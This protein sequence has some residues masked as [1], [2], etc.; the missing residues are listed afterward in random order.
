VDEQIIDKVS[1]RAA[2]RRL[3]V[4]ALGGLA[5]AAVTTIP[6][7]AKGGN[8]SKGGKRRKKRKT[9]SGDAAERLIQAKCASQGDQCRASLTEICRG[10]S[11]CLEG[12]ICCDFF[13]TCN[14]PAGLSCI[15]A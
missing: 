5:L 11:N 10:E 13:A 12:L 4:L 2:S 8:G 1:R 6:S 3:S 14:A 15:N 7:V 9:G